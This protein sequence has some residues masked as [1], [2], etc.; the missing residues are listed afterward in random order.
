VPY[1]IYGPNSNS[2][3]QDLVAGTSEFPTTLPPGAPNNDTAPG[4]NIPHP[5]FP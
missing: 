1:D 5:N 3:A 4:I 2:F